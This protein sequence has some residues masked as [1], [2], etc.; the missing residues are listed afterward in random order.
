MTETSAATGTCES[1]ANPMLIVLLAALITITLTLRTKT[2]RRFITG[3]LLDPNLDQFNR[4]T[5]FT[6]DPTGVSPWTRA[7]VVHRIAV[8]LAAV[9]LLFLYIIGLIT[10][11]YAT[12]AV[13]ATFAAAIAAWW[14]WQGWHY[15]TTRDVRRMKRDLFQALQRTVGWEDVERPNEVI[16]AKK[17]YIKTGVTALLPGTFQRL[18]TPIEHVETIASRTLGGHWEAHWDLAGEPSVI[19]RH[20]PE[21]LDEVVWDDKTSE[22]GPHD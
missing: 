10:H 3:Q 7:P 11:P 8:R 16:L 5:F 21:P 15:F 19:L 17:D 2:G 20:A 14:A 18:D 12:L 13:C 1:D 9:G 22:V 6:G 4:S